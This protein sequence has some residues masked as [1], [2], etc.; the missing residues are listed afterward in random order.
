[1][2]I[3][4]ASLRA[5]QLDHAWMTSTTN[6]SLVTPTEHEK[7]EWSRLAVD[8]YRLGLNDVGHRFS[9]SA[10]LGR[11]EPITVQ[12]FNALQD[13]YREWL[14]A[15]FPGFAHETLHARGL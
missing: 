10:A 2:P 12:A 4:D 5:W 6:R 13:E 9:G 11:N 14:I 1:M 15:G 7:A 8:A 3:D